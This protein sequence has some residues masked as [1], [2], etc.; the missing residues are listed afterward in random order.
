M[1]SETYVHQE[2]DDH[3]LPEVRGRLP[4][5]VL[6][7]VIND[8]LLPEP[9]IDEYDPKDLEVTKMSV[10]GLKSLLS[11]PDLG[12]YAN[13]SSI[14]T[15]TLIELSPREWIVD[16]LE[17]F[18]GLNH[19]EIARKLIALGSGYFVAENLE[20]FQGL[21]AD[22]AL[23]LIQV[24]WGGT[25]VI[26]N[27][28]KF[29][30]LDHSEIAHKL[31]ESGY[32]C[33]V[34]QNL[35]RF[36]GLNHVNIAFELIVRGQGDSLAD[37]LEK[38]HGL[39]HLEI[40]LKLIEA[41]LGVSV[42]KNLEKFRGLNSEVAL[43]LIDTGQGNSLISNLEKFHGLNHLEIA[44][45]LIEA[46]LGVSVAQNLER[47]QG[48]NHLEI[49]LKLIEAGVGD[50]VADILQK[51]QGLNSEVALKLIKIGQGFSVSRYL[52]KFQGLDCEVA[53]T[54]IGAGCQAAV[55]D[56]LYMFIDDSGELAKY[57]STISG[58][59]WVSP[60][61][62]V[63]A[64]YRTIS[65]KSHINKEASD[66]YGNVIAIDKSK[67]APR[68]LVDNY[69]DIATKEEPVFTPSSEINRWYGGNSYAKLKGFSSETIGH[70]MHNRIAVNV[71]SGFHYA[72]QWMQIFE[73]PNEAYDMA[74][75]R[76]IGEFFNDE[77]LNFEKLTTNNPVYEAN[78]LKIL[79][80]ADGET[81]KRLILSSKEGVAESLFFK[82]AHELVYKALTEFVDKTEQSEQSEVGESS[83]VMRFQLD[84]LDLVALRKRL[85]DMVA[86]TVTVRGNAKARA[87]H[88]EKDEV[89]ASIYQLIHDAENAVYEA[90]PEPNI[91][92]SFKELVHIRNMRDR[93]GDEVLVTKLNGMLSKLKKVSLRRTAYID[94]TQKWLLA[95]ST[96]PSEL[97]TR[98]WGDRALALASGEKDSPSSILA[99]AKLNAMNLIYDRFDKLLADGLEI[100]EFSPGEAEHF[101]LEEDETDDDD[102]N[103]EF[104]DEDEPCA[105]QSLPDDNSLIKALN[106]KSRADMNRPEVKAKLNELV[107]VL[108]ADQA[109]TALAK[110]SLW[111]R[112]EIVCETVPRVS[113][114]QTE[115]RFDQ[116][117][118]KDKQ[119][120]GED[121]KDKS[122]VF[123][124]YDKEDPRGFTIG[125]DTGCCM[126]L[127]GASESCIMAG[128]KNSNAGFMGVHS[129]ESESVIAQSFWYVNPDQPDVLVLDN[130]EANAGRDMNRL[131]EVYKRALEA[132]IKEHP[133]NG[134]KKVNL[135]LGYTE[136][137]VASLKNVEAVK[138]LIGIYSDAS[139][140]V[141]LVGESK[142]GKVK[143]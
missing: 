21:D 140:Q 60:K 57:I 105:D 39:N 113:R 107:R 62:P 69:G 88:E 6:R 104:E 5:G 36:Q 102:E 99:W 46:G 119:F 111:R 61:P 20:K 43:K 136:I 96:T 98:A 82:L 85:E 91:Q 12:G 59:E 68:E 133:E 115:V 77:V 129:P 137:N 58:Y 135:G 42:A 87:T 89:L 30:G 131:A 72:S 50:V 110:L 29:Q 108:S 120:L 41:G 73:V 103:D 40:A 130:I 31:V 4:E 1:N 66:D 18:Q 26:Q 86:S 71:E 17:K 75:A 121:E 28:E 56:K 123:E 101:E 67:F 25:Y 84:Q 143:D 3:G 64:G 27:L 22:I 13:Q 63:I 37:Y 8:A 44:L 81:R 53:I 65:Y 141:Q 10:E 142:E 79:M 128:Y 134:I 138:P 34:A 76:G 92:F 2:L 23:K 35:E 15:D 122:F 24:R 100:G 139:K 51:F 118:S 33:F 90:T 48:L 54:L 78:F 124:I 38:F 109:L 19:S 112:N 45:K 83:Q 132:W 126:T 117:D 16:N 94:D 95:S 114:W 80:T 52:Q 55:L 11:L 93:E 9:V 116:K 97:L 47:F 70:I 49:A 32:I 74:Q 14:I 125:V 127:G 7:R 106:Y